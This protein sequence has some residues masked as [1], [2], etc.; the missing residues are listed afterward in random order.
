MTSSPYQLGNRVQT[1]EVFYILLDFFTDKIVAQGQMRFS[2]MIKRYR[3]SVSYLNNDF[4]QSADE[5]LL[6]IIMIG[7]LWNEYNGRWG[8]TSIRSKEKLMNILYRWRTKYPRLKNSIDNL[9][10]KLGR[11]LLDGKKLEDV[12]VTLNNFKLLMLWLSAT[13]EFNE[14]VLRIE[15]WINFLKTI[16]EKESEQFILQVVSFAHWFKNE[17]R[18]TFKTYTYGVDAFLKNHSE[19]YK[20]KENYFFTGRSEVEYHMNMVGAAIMNRSM[21]KEFL[22]TENQILLVPSCMA[23]SE[24]CKATEY[25]KGMVCQHCNNDCNISNVTKKMLDQG[26][27]TFIIK[28]SSG[29]SEYLKQWADQKKIGLIGTAC[30]LNLLK[31]GFEM[32]RLNIPAQCVFLDYSGCKKHWTENGVPTNLCVP[33]VKEIINNNES[34]AV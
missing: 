22:E 13:N 14:E 20:G 6:D 28:H 16:P 26:V 8:S 4:A 10:G 5:N 9:R 17:S 23:K 32:K 7:V 34:K 18:L 25:M 11:S 24:N 27:S 12:E 3:C 31:G 19:K 29:F 15:S 33:R 21:Q 1:S 2:E 30:T